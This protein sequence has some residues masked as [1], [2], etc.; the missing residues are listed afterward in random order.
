M[1]KAVI[2]LKLVAETLAKRLESDNLDSAEIL[3]RN[4][5]VNPLFAEATSQT[6][7]SAACGL[8]RCA[9]FPQA[10]ADKLL[11]QY[12]GVFSR[13]ESAQQAADAASV[14]AS[15]SLNSSGS[16]SGI[17]AYINWSFQSWNCPVS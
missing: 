4:I 15:N 6:S 13:G 10:K 14:R 1:T 2:D 5:L 12:S 9:S 8:R 7:F 16:C 17:F 11:T 3:A